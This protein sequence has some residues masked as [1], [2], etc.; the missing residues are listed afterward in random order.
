[1]T[2]EKQMEQI[3][4][5]IAISSCA[6]V[7]VLNGGFITMNAFDSMKLSGGATKTAVKLKEPDGQLSAKS[8]DIA[9]WGTNNLYPQERLK[10]IRKDTEIAPLLKKKAAFIH[11]MGVMPAKFDGFKTSDDGTVYPIIVPAIDEAKEAFK[12]VNNR[13]F[14][15]WWREAIIDYCYFANIFPEVIVAPDK[16][17]VIGIAHQEATKCRLEEETS[18]K[19]GIEWCHLNSDWENYKDENGERLP[20][21]DSTRVKDIEKVRTQKGKFHYI[22][23]SNYPAPGDDYYQ[24]PTHEGYFLSGW[25]DIGIMIPEAKKYAIKKKLAIAWHIEIDTAYWPSTYPDWDKMSP[26][27]KKKT[28]TAEMKSLEENLSGVQNNGVAFTTAMQWVQH[29]EKHRSYWKIT[30]LKQGESSATDGDGIIDSRESSMHK[31]RAF[32]FDPAV[33]GLGPGRE[34]AGGGSGSDKWAAVKIMQL[35]MIPERAVP[36]DVVNF[37]FEY[38]EW[39]KDGEIFPWVFDHPML[40]TSTASEKPESQSVNP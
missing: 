33:L 37:I 34:N 24:T 12:F 8:K 17:Q 16:K 9:P 3:S 22:Y 13:K 1:M 38:N 35:M 20:V 15:R 27:K 32:D 26:E 14:K 18:K 2:K 19:N 11:G 28:V 5:N 6:R 40:A 4:E 21:I 30:P 29:S 39:H 23:L 31:Y 25:Y 7:A 10:M 36:L